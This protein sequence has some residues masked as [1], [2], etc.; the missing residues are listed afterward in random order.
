MKRVTERSDLASKQVPEY[1]SGCRQFEGEDLSKYPRRFFTLIFRLSPKSSSQCLPPKGV[2]EGAEA[3]APMGGP[4]PVQ[5]GERV[6]IP[7]RGHHQS[8]RHDGGRR[9]N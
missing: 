8:Q 5:G 6:R 4:E 1:I 7:D 2:G 9:H 3:G